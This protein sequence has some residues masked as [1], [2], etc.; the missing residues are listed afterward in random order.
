MFKEGELMYSDKIQRERNNA[1]ETNVANKI[2]DLL[3]KLQLDNDE[4]SSL[5]WIWELVQNAKD[6]VNCTGKVNINI[7]FDDISKIIKFEHNGRLFTTKNLVYLIEQV[8]TKER[9]N[10][11]EQDKR[12]TGKFGTGFL[13]THLLSEKVNVSGTLQDDGENP[14]LFDIELDRSGRDKDAIIN[15]IRNSYKQLDCSRELSKDRIIDEMD[16]NTTFTYKLSPKG[17]D[18]AKKG[19][20]ILCVALPYVLSFVPEIETVSVDTVDWIIKRG[21]IFSSNH[22]NIMVQQVKCSENGVESS[23]YVCVLSRENVSVAIEVAHDDNVYVQRYSSKLP[24]IFCDF[25]LIGTEDFSFPVVINSS[26]F[27]PT[28][29]R[30]GIYITDKEND[31]VEENKSLIMIACNL[32]K[33]LLDYVSQQGWQNIYNMVKIKPL[34]EKTWLSKTWLKGKIIDKCK[35]HI[36]YTEIVDSADGERKALYDWLDKPD[37]WIISDADAVIRE[38]VWDL[39]APIMCHKLTRRTEIHNWYDSLWSQCHNFNIN[40]LIEELQEIGNLDRLFDALGQDRNAL[41]WLNA[42]YKLLTHDHKIIDFVMD[43]KIEIFPNQNGVFCAYNSLYIDA[44]I[45]EIYKDILAILGMDCRNKLLYKNLEIGNRVVFQKYNY[46]N[47]FN[48]IQLSIRESKDRADAYK[49]L[50]ILFE[51]TINVNNKQT[52][53]LEFINIIF[54]GYLPDSIVVSK[55]SEE[56]L[57]EAMKYW[58]LQVADKISSYGNIDALAH[59]IDFSVEETV[60]EWLADY[61]EYLVKNDC[62]NLLNKTTKPILPNQNGVLKAKDELFVDSGDIDEVLKEIACTAGN[63]IREELLLSDIFLELPENRTRYLADIAPDIVR[64]I[65]EN[66]GVVK[67]QDILVKDTFKKFYKWLSDNEEKAKEHFGEILNN[68]HWLYDDREIAENMRKAEAYDDILERFNI[69]DVKGLE[70]ILKR[71][72]DIENIDK[73]EEKSE[74]S[75]ELLVQSGIYT[76]DALQQAISSNVFGDNFIHDSESDITKFEYV[77]RI[78]DRSKNNV[79]EYLKKKL[80]YDLSNIVEIDKTIFI[81]KKHNVEMYLIVR[82]SDY[83]QVILYYDSE[84]D[85]LDYEKDWELWVEDGNGDPERITFGKMLKL[86]G[87]NRIPLKRIK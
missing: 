66:Q 19:L 81:I 8:S 5:R 49:Q 64:Y 86:T 53:L 43:E 62:E 16:F 39:A 23:K 30:D 22:E 42:L 72:S 10:S 80:E 68:K 24:K 34:S 12:V 47:V 9:V 27:N 56:L 75:E 67:S 41:E 26:Y 31:K 2:M 36:L 1:Q 25:P 73:S 50:V 70:E 65:K 71:N 74:I 4:T 61:I 55:V 83:K 40:N 28:E 3:E 7:S 69:Q 29:P 6:V 35:D 76:A 48:E 37:V 51:S 82:P 20:E 33:E 79:I 38:K 21:E 18:V 14:R 58:C 63:D 54:P 60:G 59:D 32:Y 57:D 78:L 87:I 11:G 15:A 17:I 52:D 45:D 84:K 13:T 44:D 77:N 46:E 85:V